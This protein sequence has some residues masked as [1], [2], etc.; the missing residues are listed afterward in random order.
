MSTIRIKDDQ[1]DLNIYR[2]LKQ[3][4]EE[5]NRKTRIQ[6][7]GDDWLLDEMLRNSDKVHEQAE[8]IMKICHRK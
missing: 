8:I 3:L 6:L 2:R 4:E 7:Q 1:S 5:M